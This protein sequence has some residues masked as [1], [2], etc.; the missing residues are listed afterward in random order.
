MG[1]RLAADAVLLLHLGF[2]AFAGL[3]GLL[4]AWR[5]WLA[6]LH[7]P[8]AAWGVYVEL[9]GRICPLTPL[10]NELR[11]KAGGAGYS[12]SFIE[13][14]LLGVVYPPELTRELQFLLAGLL[15]LINAAVYGWLLCRRRA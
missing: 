1:Y 8:A 12:G 15:L 10:E 7:L 5:R 13:H 11:I 4:A 6:A 3:G 14:Y 9:S 2:I